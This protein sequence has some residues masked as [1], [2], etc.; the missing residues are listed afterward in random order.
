[1]N[2]CRTCGGFT[3]EG[4]GCSALNYFPNATIAEYGMIHGN[5][6]EDRVNK[7]KAEIKTR[8]PVA[9]SINADP[10]RDFTGGSVF[11]DESAGK[12][13][14][15]V[16]SIFGWGKDENGKEFWHCRNSWGYYWGE[17]VFFRVATGKNM[18]GVESDVAWATPGA[19]TIENVPCSEGGEMCGG[20]VN[21]LHGGGRIRF[22][23]QEY[24]DPS[25]YLAESSSTYLR[26]KK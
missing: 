7:I 24:I 14:N 20:E 18:L 16:I 8:G 19:F 11:D 12:M 9:A 21:E 3:Q 22:K 26:E 4:G 13:Q 10:L 2:T 15:H 6:I 23:A 1:M 25:V 17:Q 5:S